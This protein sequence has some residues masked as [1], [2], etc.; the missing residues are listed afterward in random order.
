MTELDVIKHIV[1][2]DAILGFVAKTP[3]HYWL[4]GIGDV[5]YEIFKSL[6]DNDFIIDAEV[7]H[8]GSVQ[9]YDLTQKG[10]EYYEKNS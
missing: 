3:S 9:L 1:E 4:N 10:R 2:D 6:Y 7:I 8:G 5:S